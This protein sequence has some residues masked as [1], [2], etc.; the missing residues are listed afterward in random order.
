MNK[1]I[2]ININGI[3]FH[4]E[5]D[6]YEILRSYM[7][8]VKRHFADEE[9]SV[10]ITTDIENRIAEMFSEILARENRPVV[11]TA[12][13]TT[14]ISQ[15]GTIEDFETE[16]EQKT[17]YTDGQAAQNRKLFRDPDDHLLGGVCAGIANYFDIEIVWIR[18]AFAI[19]TFI[20]GSGAIAYLVLWI[21]VP[22]AVT[23]ADKMAMK[24]ERLDLK[25]FVRNFEEEVKNVHHTL[26][27]AGTHAQPFAYK[28]RDFVGDFFEHF[29]YFLGGAGKVLLK[30]IGVFILLVCF[31][32]V[33]SAVVALAFFTAQ[34][35]DVFH[36]FPFSLI[37]HGYSDIIAFSAFGVIVIPLLA[38][39]LSTLRVIFN[40]K[41]MGRSTGYT[42]LIIWIVALGL[43]GYHASKVAADFREE[44]S[45]SQNIGIEVPSKNVY[46][47]KLNEIKYL[48]KEDSIQLDINDKFKG[49]VIL[50]DEDDDDNRHETR[51][52]SVHI[53]IERSDV[54]QPVLVES[55][56]ARGYSKKQALSN[57]MNTSYYF[58]QQDSVLSFDRALKVP[59]N[60]L[61]RN[62]E[63]NLTLKIP[64]NATLVIDKNMERYIQDVSLWE[65]NEKNKRDNN[66]PA[67]F[68][69]TGTGLQC[70]V[71]TV[72]GWSNNNSVV[73]TAVQQ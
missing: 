71:D 8:D 68:I 46:Y 20:G 14:I 72:V 58:N 18:L 44:A 35:R 27:N 31:G 12:D 6:A 59:F 1:T 11:V 43:L 21:I 67:T 32:F 56:R 5:E 23:R 48:S 70:K 60:A 9:D 22:K 3:V 37:N 65:C 69:M 42:L 15:M 33:I 52:Q 63:V 61:W 34:G 7:T 47:L 73:D 45:F 4:I 25:G 50:N 62:Q 13:V 40:S 29:R 51:P 66:S 24:G 53:F 36:L 57:A 26:S 2:I 19:I 28:V 41:V 64:Q 55:F 17:A 30:I 39:I 49:R 16:A 38:I 54:A 10:E